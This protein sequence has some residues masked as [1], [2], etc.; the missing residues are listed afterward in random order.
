MLLL[1]LSLSL[2]QTDINWFLLR[3]FDLVFRDH[4][5]DYFGEKQAF[6]SLSAMLIFVHLFDISFCTFKSLS[7]CT[8]MGKCATSSVTVC[9]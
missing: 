2:G 3:M 8:D 7:T 9:R 5:T 4:S 6:R 1:E